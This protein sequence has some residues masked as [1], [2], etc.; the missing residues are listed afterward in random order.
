MLRNIKRAGMTAERKRLKVLVCPS[1]R[2]DKGLK[3]LVGR[4]FHLLIP[5]R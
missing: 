2:D 4:F 5:N 1:E 3:V